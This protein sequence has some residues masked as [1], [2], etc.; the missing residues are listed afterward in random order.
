MEGWWGCIIWKSKWVKV[1][2][3]SWNVNTQSNFAYNQYCFDISDDKSQSSIRVNSQLW[4][5]YYDNVGTQHG[6]SSFNYKVNS[7]QK[8]YSASM[9]KGNVQHNIETRGLNHI[10]TIAVHNSNGFFINLKK[11]YKSMN[12]IDNVL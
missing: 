5:I 7:A 6:Q 4:E 11:K 1:P 12:Y 8:E 10:N 2:L 9:N 3:Y